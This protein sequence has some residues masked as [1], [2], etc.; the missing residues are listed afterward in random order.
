MFDYFNNAPAIPNE[1]KRIEF[2]DSDYDYDNTTYGPKL[3]DWLNASRTI[4]SVS[5]PITIAL[6]S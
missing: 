4:S 3:R 5:S 2:L 6:L 1:V